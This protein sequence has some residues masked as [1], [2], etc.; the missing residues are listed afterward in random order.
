M[1]LDIAQGWCVP[2]IEYELKQRGFAQCFRRLRFFLSRLSLPC[3]GTAGHYQGRKSN[4]QGSPQAH[5]P[6]PLSSNIDVLFP[7][8]ITTLRRVGSEN[9]MYLGVLLGLHKY[10]PSCESENPANSN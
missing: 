10:P 8:I 2:A 1:L 7:H 3:S 6:F 4:Q 5:F 9:P